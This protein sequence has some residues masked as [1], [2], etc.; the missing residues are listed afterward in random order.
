[1]QN[2]SPDTRQAYGHKN[3]QALLFTLH[4]PESGTAENCISA[5]HKHQIKLIR[6]KGKKDWRAILVV[7]FAV[8]MTSAALLSSWLM[9]LF[10][11]LIAIVAA[12]AGAKNHEK[13][14]MINLEIDAAQS[15]LTE[16]LKIKL[17][18]RFS[19]FY[20]AQCPR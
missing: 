9:S 2:D 4:Q 12:Y 1:M 7:F 16:L 5:I 8:L 10:L 15:L 14:S 17:Q 18:E 11:V 20:G 13:I 19:R 3:L 6:E